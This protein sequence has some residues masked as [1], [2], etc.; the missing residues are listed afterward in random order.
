MKGSKYCNLFC[1]SLNEME[2]MTHQLVANPV[3]RSIQVR[4]QKSIFIISFKWGGEK[5]KL[6]E[7]ER[8]KKLIEG[9]DRGRTILLV[10]VKRDDKLQECVLFWLRRCKDFWLSGC[11]VIVL[12]AVGRRRFSPFSEAQPVLIYQLGNKYDFVRDLFLWGGIV[13]N[14]LDQGKGF[15]SYK[16]Y[17]KVA[18]YY[19]SINI[20]SHGKER[21]RE[22]ETRIL[23]FA[24][25]NIRFNSRPLPWLLLLCD[26]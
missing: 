10:N 1:L 11:F 21:E 17:S 24:T 19:S 25:Q 8:R 9:K 6:F 16:I 23:L 18:F 15:P 12:H 13:M 5:R 14:S 4:I 26:F 22:R 7:I 20:F 2:G 3:C